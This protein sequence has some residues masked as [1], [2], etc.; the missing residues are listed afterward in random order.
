MRALFGAGQDYVIGLDVGVASVKWA[1]FAKKE[2]GLHLLKADRREIDASAAPEERKQKTIEA[3]RDVAGDLEVKRSKVFANVNCPRTAVRRV[4]VPAA[5]SK[6]LKEWIGS[7]CKD[8][9][10]FATDDARVDFEITEEFSGKD[11]PRFHALVAT[12]PTSTVDDALALLEKAGIRPAAL[13]PVPCALEHLAEA[14]GVEEGRVKC[15][16][17][18]GETFTELVV[19]CLRGGVADTAKRPDLLFSRKIP[20]GGRDFTKALTAALVSDKG[21]IQLGPGEAEAFKKE[22]GIP[23]SDAVIPE[24]KISAA[25]AA[26]MTRLPLDQLAGEI[27]R[28]FDYCH[29][30][31]ADARVDSVTLFGGGGSLKGLAEFLADRLGVRCK[32]GNPFASPALRASPAPLPENPAPFATAVGLAIG[33]GRGINLIPPE[34]RSGTEKTIRRTAFKALA[35]V[36]ATGFVL[37]A[38]G[39]VIQGESDKKKTAGAVAEI[40]SLRPAVEEAERAKFIGSFLAGEPYWDDL[41]KELALR[42]PENVRLTEITKR[43]RGLVLK[44]VVAFQEREETL[45]NFMFALEKGAFKNVRLVTTRELNGR[46]MNEFELAAWVDGQ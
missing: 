31:A 34:A 28:C 4:A 36:V 5:P 26:S 37:L 2:G 46:Q 11:G 38:A 23:A 25:Q 10:P 19:F 9:F 15:L 42:V 30:E 14:G 45:S 13:A 1:L 29:E 27:E 44:G 20:V 41:F 18:I 24:G 8:Y 22:W 32:R 35:A 3:L 33:A 39:F 7:H 6:A 40:E 43:G 21:K 12:S 16:V 17:E